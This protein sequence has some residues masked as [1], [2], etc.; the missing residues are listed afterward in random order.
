MTPNFVPSAIS[1][2]SAVKVPECK[3]HLRQRGLE[4]LRRSTLML[5]ARRYMGPR[6]IAS[7]VSRSVAARRT[8]WKS[9]SQSFEF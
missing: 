7:L 5:S 3:D 9:R 1:R 6:S 4:V 8:S 2:V